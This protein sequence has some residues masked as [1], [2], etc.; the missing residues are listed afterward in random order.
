MNIRIKFRKYGSMKFI[1]HLDIMRYFQKAMRRAEIDICYSEGYSPHQIMSF[2]A[3]LGVGIT[4]D[5][6]Y[7]DI[8]VHSVSNSKDSIEQLNQVM[9]EG[10]EVTE[11]VKLPEKA[12]NAMSIVAAADYTVSFR[13]GYE[14]DFPW[15]DDFDSFMKQNSIKILKK[16]KKSEKEV[17]IKP[18]IYSYQIN[19][20]KINFQLAAGSAN[21]LKPELIMEA[22]G[23]YLNYEFAAFTFC[24]HRREIYAN[25]GEDEKLSLVPLGDLGDNIE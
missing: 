3:P 13:K 20:D 5:G 6:E 16:T 21:N 24:I 23:N 2:A 4:S 14:L 19:D 10:I 22:F 25:I 15:D 12:Q 9:A 17:D 11:F 1:G 8:E 18:L 7:L